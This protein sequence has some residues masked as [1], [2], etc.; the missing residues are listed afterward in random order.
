MSAPAAIDLRQHV[1]PGA[2][3][4]WGQ[5]TGEPF[6]LTETLAS[7]APMLGGLRAFVGMSVREIFDP[8][9]AEHIDF[10]FAGGAATNG[11]LAVDGALNALPVHL[12]Q[13]PRFLENGQ[14][15]CDVALVHG[16]QGA[17][18]GAVNL[19]LSADYMG[20]AAAVAP[21][22]IAEVN[23]ALPQTF[24][25]TEIP[26]SRI[27]ARIETNRPPAT[28]E[29][30]P[31]GD[32]ERAIGGHIAR[33]I[34]DGATIQMGVG[35]LPDAALAALANRKDLGIHTGLM[36]DAALDLIE[37]DVVTNRRKEADTGRSMT[38]LLYGTERLY[39]WAHRNDALRLRSARYTHDPDVLA[40]FGAF[41]AINAALEVD[42]TGQVNGEIAGGRP[43][44]LVGG[45]VDFARAAMR[46]PGGR[47]IIALRSTA[48]RGRVSSIVAGL[49]RGIVTTA[50][51]DVD[52]VVT[53]YGIAELA[54]I[55][56]FER[57]RRLIA[58][59]H[60]EFRS[61]L[62]QASDQLA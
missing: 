26:D 16:A 28:F 36:S 31:I 50:R 53:E 40:Q 15:P 12:S 38:A 8:A 41:F 48:R 27:T 14:I 4:V 44:G 5:I 10:A 2:A 51:T 1:D 20:D 60:P 42:L 61:E 43:V 62:E 45:Q 54:G 30:P 25:D 37:A 21:I 55:P 3:L 13:I 35:S 22:V 59:A 9:A 7:Q 56:V 32:V 24:G 6:T 29:P 11:R 49:S 58:I 46:S 34:P 57:A 23:A 17:T 47:S 19:G 39:R 18:D 52:V 33:L